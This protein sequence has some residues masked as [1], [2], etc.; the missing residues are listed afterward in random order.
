MEEH[1]AYAQCE[2]R[3]DIKSLTRYKGAWVHPLSDE[4]ITGILITE[5]YTELLATDKFAHPDGTWKEC[6][7]NGLKYRNLSKV[8]WI[9]PV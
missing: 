9:R 4:T 1:W 5:D 6:G 7:I 8:P 2:R 3:P